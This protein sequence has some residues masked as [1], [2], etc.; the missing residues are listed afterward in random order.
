M[1]AIGIGSAKEDANFEIEAK[2]TDESESKLDDDLEL[3]IDNQEKN[4]MESEMKL[5]EVD[6][7]MDSETKSKINY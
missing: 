5:S 4:E 3:E 7:K 1:I 2:K 6:P